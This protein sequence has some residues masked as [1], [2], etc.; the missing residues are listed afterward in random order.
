VSSPIVPADGSSGLSFFGLF[1]GMCTVWAG[2][3]VAPPHPRVYRF[4]AANSFP[5]HT[6]VAETNFVV[7]STEPLP[8][9]ESSFPLPIGHPPEGRA[10]NAQSRSLQFRSMRQR[11][12]GGFQRQMTTGPQMP[13]SNRRPARAGLAR[14]PPVSRSL[15]GRSARMSVWLLGIPQR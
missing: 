4:R 7:L 13:L 5:L 3:L 1:R 15:L 6:K 2:R 14:R 12:N 10:T 11:A 8:S 9:K